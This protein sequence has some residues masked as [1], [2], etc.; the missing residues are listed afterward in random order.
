MNSRDYKVICVLGNGF[1][2]DLGLKT[3][4][5]D[6]IESDFFRKN[7]DVN[8]KSQGYNLFNYLNYKYKQ[9]D[10]IDIEKELTQLALKKTSVRSNGINVIRKAKSPLVEKESFY[11]LHESLTDY[12]SDINYNEIKTNSYAAN[13]MMILKN[14]FVKILTYN[15]TNLRRI[16][17][18]RA[19]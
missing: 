17:I 1:D 15:Y 18:G 19:S 7:I 8:D 12:L 16:E 13:L 10:W 9:A 6:F 5:S 2:L 3:K 4:Y 11:K 14:K